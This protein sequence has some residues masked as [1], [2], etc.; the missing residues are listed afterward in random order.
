MLHRRYMGQRGD[1]SRCCQIPH[2]YMGWTFDFTV[3]ILHLYIIIDRLKYAQLQLAE[4]RTQGAVPISR[5]SLGRIISKISTAQNAL[6]LSR[7]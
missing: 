5:R 2:V 1:I 4:F 7:A 3:A 6:R